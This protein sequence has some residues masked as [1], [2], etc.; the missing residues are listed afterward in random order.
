MSGI[1]CFGEV[2]MRLA[3]PAQTLIFQEKLFEASFCG[4]EAN[5]AVALAGLGHQCEMVTV[6]PDN[7]LGAAAVAELGHFNVGTDL[8]DQ[9]P[10]RMGLFF[11]SP[12]A[13]A[14]PARILYDRAGS[15]FTELKPNQFDW[16]AILDGKD[17]LFV[18][19]ITAA[20]GSAALTVLR[21]A[22][23]AA[24]DSGIKIAFDCNYRPSLWQGRTT[25]AAAV[26][27]E[28]SLR[29]NLLFAGR[30][31]IGMMLDRTF[32]QVDPDEAFQS[33]A[34]AIFEQTEN[35]DF[36]AATR[37]EIISS[38]NNRLNAL[39]ASRETLAVS[40]T[41]ALE[42]IV[43]RI[44]TGDAFASGILHGLIEG[45]SVQPCA[46][47]ALATA[48]WSHSVKGDFLRASRNDIE[49]LLTGQADVRR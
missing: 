9:A 20:L 33:A 3:S 21:T 30:R 41:I 28:L 5:V 14:R 25:E 11:L 43:D 16:N 39:L 1:V 26:M 44:G 7:Q 37:R 8:I 31:A 6:L 45:M 2:L 22:L 38:D 34:S 46:E 35:L 15:A 42:Q 12:G 32:D 48:Q 47:F 19:G 17:W 49:D 13:M 24:H 40:N 18:S 23:D 36:V 4:A 27:K 10:G 29:A